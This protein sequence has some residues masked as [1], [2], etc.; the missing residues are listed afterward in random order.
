MRILVG[1]V[2][3][4]GRLTLVA[5][6]AAL[7][8]LGV[9]A[10]VAAVSARGYL[11]QEAHVYARTSASHAELVPDRLR[12]DPRVEIQVHRIR[13]LSALRDG[14]MPQS[15]FVTVLHTD[16]PAPL[17]LLPWTDPAD[18]QPFL[19]DISPRGTNP[20]A[21]LLYVYS[22]LR[23]EQARL[24]A[25]VWGLTAAVT[26]TTGLVA[27]ATWFAAG[28]ALRAAAPNNSP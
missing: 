16:E 10:V 23:Y 6:I 11:L 4:R 26:L 24:N 25:V 28:R 19:E 8:P 27:A 3:M 9:G 7:L 5:A 1:P 22:P 21:P 20:D 17:S 15:T 13:E 2:S 18:R 12:G 14:G